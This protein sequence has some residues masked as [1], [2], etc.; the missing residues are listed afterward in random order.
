MFF[1]LLGFLNIFTGDLGGVGGGL[2]GMGVGLVSIWLRNKAGRGFIHFC[3]V[4]FGISFSVRTE[5]FVERIYYF[6]CS[7][8][9]I[10]FV[11]LG[12]G[13]FVFMI[14]DVIH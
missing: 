14:I 10:A 6:F 12:L 11:L 2:F 9:G 13:K 7:V 3:D 4:T 8:F 5:K 1:V